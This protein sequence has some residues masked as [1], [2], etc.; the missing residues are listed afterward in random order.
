MEFI[1]LK[2]WKPISRRVSAKKTLFQ[3]S[4]SILAYNNAIIT[5]NS[6]L[7]MRGDRS[8]FAEAGR[9]PILARGRNIKN[10]LSV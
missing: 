1:K 6:M 8:N 7:N 5:I 3:A 4:F 2:V 10:S 9:L